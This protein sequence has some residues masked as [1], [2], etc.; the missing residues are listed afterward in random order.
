MWRVKKGKEQLLGYFNKRYPQLIAEQHEQHLKQFIEI[1]QQ[2]MT[3]KNKQD[4]KT[5]KDNEKEENKEKVVEAEILV[6]KQ[7]DNHTIQSYWQAV[8][9]SC[10][11][12]NFNIEELMSWLHCLPI[13][14]DKA[15]N[16]W[17]ISQAGITALSFQT[18]R[19]SMPNAQHLQ[20]EPIVKE[21]IEAKLS[22]VANTPKLPH[23]IDISVRLE[24]ARLKNAEI[25][26]LTIGKPSEFKVWQLP[27]VNP[28]FIPR[29]K[30]TD[31]LKEKLPQKKAEESRRK[32]KKAGEESAKLLLT[33]ATG[34]GGIGKTE[35]ARHF[36][37]NKE[38]SDHYQRRFWLTATTASQIRN[39][40]MQ[41]AVYLGLIESKKYIEDKELIHLI[42]RWLSI[43][44]GW[45][46]MLDNADDYNS[47]VN[48][49][50][51]EG[52]AVLV[53]TREPTPGTMNSKQIV[54]VPLL[55]PEEAIT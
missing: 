20:I 17:Q 13:N 24:D 4:N 50:P 23:E 10:E 40:F 26:I 16:Q 25:D 42:H 27:T 11:N 3:I 28:Y 31:E 44:P 51:K 47:I 37:T 36:I 46:M 34:M 12:I 6:N 21:A 35:L 32:Q 14:Y 8:E 5:L 33:A 30:L 15:N 18:N 49:I 38:L 53:T 55:E 39:E 52:G 22:E 29:S 2:E 9:S 19:K 48:W 7:I 41:L 45:L 54:Q 43:N 1:L